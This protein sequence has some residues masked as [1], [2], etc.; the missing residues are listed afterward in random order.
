MRWSISFSDLWVTLLDGVNENMTGIE[1]KYTTMAH[2]ELTG[3]CFWLLDGVKDDPNVNDTFWSLPERTRTKVEW[4]R[5]RGVGI[6]Q[7]LPHGTIFTSMQ[8]VRETP[9]RVFDFSQYVESDHDEA[10]L[11]YQ[12]G[13]S[14]GYMELQAIKEYVRNHPAA[15]WK[16]IFANVQ[17]HYSSPSSLSGSMSQ[18]RGFSL[19]EFKKS[20]RL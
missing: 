19:A 6:I 1:L 8:S 17:N 4:C 15:D 13:V 2:L 10:G 14:A 16:E 11:P 20:L 5:D 12:K 3:N 7:I 9:Y 18:W